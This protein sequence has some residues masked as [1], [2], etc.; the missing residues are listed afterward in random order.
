[1]GGYMRIS[2]ILH[3]AIRQTETEIDRVTSQRKVIELT[4]MDSNERMKMD[5]PLKVEQ[6]QLEIL[7]KYLKMPIF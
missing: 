2:E 3:N 1:M 4:D 6:E 7:L 5:E